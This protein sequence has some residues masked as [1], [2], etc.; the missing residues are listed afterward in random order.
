MT[1]HDPAT[2]ARGRVRV[3]ATLIAVLAV[4]AMT[5][6]PA[7]GSGTFSERYAFSVSFEHEDCG[8][9]IS[10]TYEERG[11]YQAKVSGREMNNYDWRL[12]ETNPANGKWFERGGNGIGL[13]VKFTLVEGTI[14]RFTSI[15]AGNSISIW[16]MDGNRLFHDR[17]LLEVTYLLDTKGDAD[18]D[19][20]EVVEG[21]FE[22]T[23][24]RGKH[25]AN[26]YFAEN[27]WCEFVT[28]LIG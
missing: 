15:D 2:G 18:P 8:F 17:G 21:T 3:E 24:D 28:D 23:A 11:L 14:Y 27:D 16:D 26:E 20:D 22:L 25:P 19:N 12:V 6:A 9:P 5:A 7:A 4:F 13:D 10:A 1:H